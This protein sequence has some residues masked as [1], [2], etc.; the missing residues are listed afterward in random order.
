LDGLLEVDGLDRRHLVVCG[1]E[2]T[3]HIQP[4][5][6]PSARVAF[7]TPHGAYRR[8]YQDLSFPRYTR[9]VDDAADMARVIRGEKAIDFTPKHDLAV[10][11]AV[12][13]AS[14]RPLDA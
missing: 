3:F 1:T 6:N 14:E 11:T 5:D 8:G 2:G 13:Q 9:Y 10:Q 7:S 12:L 4:L